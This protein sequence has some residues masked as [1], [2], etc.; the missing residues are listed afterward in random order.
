[1]V[2]ASHLDVREM[3]SINV[4]CILMKLEC[5]VMNVECSVMNV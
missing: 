1:M 2:E 3:N 4:K 5:T